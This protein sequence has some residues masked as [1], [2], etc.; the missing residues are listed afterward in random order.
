MNISYDVPMIF[1]QIAEGSLHKSSFYESKGHS[2]EKRT[3][4]ENV[5]GRHSH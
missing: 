2:I 3:R 1:I 4:I 5:T